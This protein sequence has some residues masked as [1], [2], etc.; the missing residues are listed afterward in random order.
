[1]SIFCVVC[2][3]GSKQYQCGQSLERIGQEDKSDPAIQG[4]LSM[5]DPTALF[6][7]FSRYLLGVGDNNQM[8]EKNQP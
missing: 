2:S 5:K 6:S 4:L 8:K 7:S 1:M 3:L